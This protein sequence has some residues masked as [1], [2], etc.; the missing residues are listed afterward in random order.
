MPTF[1]MSL[2]KSSSVCAGSLCPL[3]VRVIFFPVGSIPPPDFTSLVLWPQESHKVAIITTSLKCGISEKNQHT[4]VVNRTHTLLVYTL[5]CLFSWKVTPN[6]MQGYLWHLFLNQLFMLFH[7]VALVL[8][9]MVAFSTI[10][11]LVDFLQQPI[12]FFEISG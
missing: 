1:R 9:S 8:L 12:R 2:L 6:T 11:W 4:L 5:H 10:F 3:T 7:M